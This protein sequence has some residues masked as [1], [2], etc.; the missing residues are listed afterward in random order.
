MSV[1]L[2]RGA[3]FEKITFF[4]PDSVWDGYSKKE[5]PG[6]RTTSI[7]ETMLASFFVDVFIDFLSLFLLA[8]WDTVWS[9]WAIFVLEKCIQKSY[10]FRV[11]F[12]RDFQRISEGPRP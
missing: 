10:V 11:C 1:S 8:F 7:L 2:K 5:A 9:I 6:Y 3:I 12:W 4:R